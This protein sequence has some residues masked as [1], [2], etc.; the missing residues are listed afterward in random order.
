MNG[1]P[2]L[3]DVL[4]LVVTRL[5]L[6]RMANSEEKGMIEPRNGLRS[7]AAYLV[8]TQYDLCH[9]R[10]SDPLT[11]QFYHPRARL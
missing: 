7:I 4:A 3:R 6:R 5:I 1:P 2:W 11:G 10:M 9:I 8:P